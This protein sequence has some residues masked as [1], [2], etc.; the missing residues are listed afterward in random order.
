VS[1]D[2]RS[3]CSWAQGPAATRSGRWWTGVW[4][5]GR[6]LFGALALVLFACAA[7]GAY[8]RG[9]EAMGRGDEAEAV[10]QLEQAVREQPERTEGW[11]ELARARLRVGATGPA[12]AAID[13]ALELAPDDL[14]ALL[15]R[16]QI[17]ATAGD[18]ALARADAEVVAA[19]S[20]AARELEEAAVVLARTGA[21]AAAIAAARAA[22]ERSGGAAATYTNLAVITAELGMADAAMEAASDGLR[23]HPDDLGLLQTDAALRLRTGDLAGARR[24]YEQLIARHPQPG[25]VHLALALVSFEQGDLVSARNHAARALQLDG[26]TR[27]DVHA[28]WV[29]VLRATGEDARARADLAAGLRRFPSDPQLRRLA[30]ADGAPTRP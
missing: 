20:A 19:R 29:V 16:A 21:P 12:R 1:C 30:A 9:I 4:R 28:T 2:R 5:G 23:R 14:A 24:R 8:E 18:L 10:R 25:R 15:L 17:R 26:Q 27:A 7:A 6:G 13:R 3:R 11:R 22:V